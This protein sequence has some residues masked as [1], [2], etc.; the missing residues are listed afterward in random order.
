MDVC[1]RSFAGLTP[2]LAFAFLPL[3]EA[4]WVSLGMT[5]LLLIVLGCGRARIGQR[6]VLPTVLQTV[7]VAGMAAIAGI[8]IGQLINQ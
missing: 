7:G 8:L 1:F 2:V 3:A 4:R 6:A 5:L